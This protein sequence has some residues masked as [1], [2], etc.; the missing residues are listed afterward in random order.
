[1]LSALGSTTLFSVLFMLF[2][3]D[4]HIMGLDIE[5]VKPLKSLDHKCS[6]EIVPK[7]VNANAHQILSYEFLWAHEGKSPPPCN[8]VSD[9]LTLFLL[10]LSVLGLQPFLGCCW[11]CLRNW[12]SITYQLKMEFSG[13]LHTMWRLHSS[14]IVGIIILIV[15]PSWQVGHLSRAHI[16]SEVGYVIGLPFPVPLNILKN[17]EEVRGNGT[18]STQIGQGLVIVQVTSASLSFGTLVS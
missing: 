4:F 2:E 1:M 8:E 17:F 11:N 16:V 18:S 10:C 12:C 15:Y 6:R 14:I 7:T 3:V 9:V 13:D 5:D